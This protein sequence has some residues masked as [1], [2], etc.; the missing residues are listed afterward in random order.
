MPSIEQLLQMMAAL[1]DPEKGCPWDKQQDFS[2]IAPYTIEEAYEVADAIDRNA[3]ND[4][5][6]ELGDLLFQVVYHAQ[7]ASEKALF[8]FDDIVAAISQK[9]ESRHP[10]VFAGEVIGSAGEQTRAWEQHK[11]R[12]RQATGRGTGLLDGISQ[13]IPALARARKLQQRAATVG[14][15]W[16]EPGAVMEKLQEELQE[17]S[18]A[19]LTAGQAEVDNDTAGNT[20]VREELGD[21]LFS[22]V[23]LARHL[24]VD[25][26]AALR[27]AN[28]K[29][30]KRFRYMEA[31]LAENGGNPEQV[32]L[33]RMETLWQEAKQ[34]CG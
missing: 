2:S 10:H 30:E 14:F 5:C 22:C 18:S 32:S 23:N 20:A 17:L 16:S 12:E 31:R 24:L 34:Q 19:M 7:M 15:D 25:A 33:E 3:M 27:A 9:I 6:N 28:R 4:L 26:E 8:D 29:F 13:S 1:R 21:L 11:R